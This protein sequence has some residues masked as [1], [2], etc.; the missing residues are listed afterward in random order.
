MFNWLRNP[1]DKHG[2]HALA[3][4]VRRALKDFG[5]SH[6]DVNASDVAVFIGSGD[7]RTSVVVEE[8]YDDLKGRRWRVTVPLRYTQNEWVN[9]LAGE[10]P[11]PREALRMALLV[12]LAGALDIA[13]ERMPPVFDAVGEPDFRP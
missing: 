8:L 3:R 10:T 1:F 9:R 11:D 5:M 6:T 13:L 7:A 4:W 2:P 12:V